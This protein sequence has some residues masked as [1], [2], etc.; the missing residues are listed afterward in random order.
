[1]TTNGVPCTG[2]GQVLEDFRLM[3]EY[4][5]QADIKPRLDELLFFEAPA[6]L[7]ANWSIAKN[8]LFNWPILTDGTNILD[9]ACRMPSFS[10]P[11][12]LE[13]P[14]AGVNDGENGN[15]TSVRAC[16]A[17][18]RQTI[19]RRKAPPQRGTFLPS[20]PS[21][22]HRSEARAISDR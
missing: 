15:A 22:Q 17:K 20:A 9:V 11:S 6:N 18:K 3:G 7:P 4:F 21:A 10:T 1:M 19:R 12:L 14:A 16:C 13:T 2:G 5:A 8:T